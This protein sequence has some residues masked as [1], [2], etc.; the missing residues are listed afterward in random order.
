MGLGT[1]LDNIEW[2][3]H[4]P[5]ESPQ[6]PATDEVIEE[7]RGRALGLWEELL[8]W[9]PQGEKQG[10][11]GAI[12]EQNGYQATVALPHAVLRA[13]EE[14]KGV[15]GVVEATE[16]PG[17]LEEGLHPFKGSEGGLSCAC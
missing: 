16:V 17:V 1:R 13:Q 2:V 12:A 3:E 9:A 8:Q 10:V 6:Q 4:D 5:Q 15:D 7:V 11:A 14:A